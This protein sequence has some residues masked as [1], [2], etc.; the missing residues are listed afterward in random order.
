MPGHAPLWIRLIFRLLV[1]DCRPCFLLTCRY[2]PQPLV[3]AIHEVI[4]VFP[5]SRVESIH[6]LL[7]VRWLEASL[8]AKWLCVEVRR[9]TMHPTSCKAES[10]KLPNPPLRPHLLVSGFL[11][12]D[13]RQRSLLTS[14]GPFTFSFPSFHSSHVCFPPASL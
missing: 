7:D 2:S 3:R 4:R 12:S 6:P 13:S 10:A 11:Q 14:K 5:Q 9:V 1:L 8:E